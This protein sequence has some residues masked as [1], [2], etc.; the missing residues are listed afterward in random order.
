MQ[1][2]KNKELEEQERKK[3]KLKTNQRINRKSID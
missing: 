1:Q 3:E 2:T